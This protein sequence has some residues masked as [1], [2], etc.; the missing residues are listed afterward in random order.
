[1]KFWILAVSWVR[2]VWELQERKKKQRVSA[3]ETEKGGMLSSMLKSSRMMMRRFPSQ[4]R[5][6]S[7]EFD[8]E[9]FLNDM[10]EQVK[11]V[12]K[13]TDPYSS[14][15]ILRSLVKS[16]TLSYWDMKENPEKFFMAHRL[17]AT[18]GLGGFGIRFT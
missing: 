15:E 9:I 10:L 11:N 12:P 8:Q 13:A 1:M 6:F 4:Y 16:N 17:L 5:Y 7:S 2:I 3:S 18:I 14:S